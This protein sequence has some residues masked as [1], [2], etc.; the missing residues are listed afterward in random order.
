MGA[1]QFLKVIVPSVT[2]RRQRDE[3]ALSSKAPPMEMVSVDAHAVGPIRNR[4]PARARVVDIARPLF[5]GRD[6]MRIR[7]SLGL[8]IDE[9]AHLASVT[10]CQVRHIEEDAADTRYRRSLEVVDSVC[11]ALHFHI[12]SR[13]KRR[14]GVAEG[15]RRSTCSRP[16]CRAPD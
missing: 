13:L 14:E 3:T 16:R 4:V 15:R 11:A 7:V 8:T 5:S 2:G 10:P 6:L 1:V 12:M 9:V